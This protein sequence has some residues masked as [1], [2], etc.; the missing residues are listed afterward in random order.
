IRDLNKYTV[1]TLKELLR[2]R[3]LAT[4]G[5]KHILVVVDAFSKLIWLHTTKPTFT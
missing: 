5:T 2:Q 4:S 3:T 1:E